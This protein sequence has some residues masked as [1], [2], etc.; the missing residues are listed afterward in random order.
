MMEK[1]H[2]ICMNITLLDEPE[3]LTFL[4]TL[5]LLRRRHQNQTTSS[6]NIRL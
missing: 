2:K 3:P 5:N 1:T 4:Q 6:T